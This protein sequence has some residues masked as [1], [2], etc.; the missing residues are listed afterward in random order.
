MRVGIGHDTHRFE[1][2]PARQPLR[3]GGVEVP[4]DRSLVGHSDAD[5]LLH[6]IT[7]AILGALGTGDI[8]E[9]FPDTAEE[10]RGRHSAD[11]LKF[12]VELARGKG[13]HIENLDT[14]IFA[15]T[16]KL[17][18]YKEQMK[19]TIAGLLDISP[20]AVGVKAKTGEGVGIIG[21][22]EAISAEAVVLL[23]KRTEGNM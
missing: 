9:N 19:Q 11:F 23:K 6:A 17:G 10:N 21:R 2:G 1:T 4:S 18:P 7:D 15:E 12:A 16:P 20:D 3:L 22:N 5:V 8:G 14:I 13:W